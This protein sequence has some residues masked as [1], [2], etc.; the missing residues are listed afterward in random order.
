MNLIIENSKSN[1]KDIVLKII[2]DRKKEIF[3]FFNSNV[4]DLPFN[5]Y[6]YDSIE[7]LVD[8]LRKRGFD[9]DP[10]YMCAC[11]KDEDN[12]LNFFEPKD[13]P[14]NNEW[15]KEEYEDVILHELIHAIQFNLFGSAPEWLCEGIAKY[16]DGTYSYGIKWL[17]EDYINDEPIP[18]QS[19]IENEFG[20]H[21]Y[22]SYDYAYLM[23]SYLIESMGKDEFV[24]LIK[25][26]K[27]NSVKD[28]L[29]DK[30]INY[31]NSKYFSNYLDKYLN[32]DID[33]P[34]YLFHGSCKRL[35][36]LIP[37]LSHDSNGNSN[38]IADAIFLFPSF[39]KSTP[40]AFKDTIKECSEGLDWNFEIPSDNDFPLMKMSNVN[41]DED[42]VGYI[43]VFENSN[44]M[45]KDDD[46][47]QY[48][49]YKE[50]V[51]IDVVEVCFKDYMKYYDNQDEHKKR[52]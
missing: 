3:N 46:S 2:N 7:S 40:Y 43:Y 4:I 10:D 17:L 42:I 50:L 8:G 28:G 6:I 33:N 5:V 32:Q 38:N 13:N 30:A 37:R 48:K 52:R 27:I 31:Y 26:N 45:I 9:K 34:K 16:L 20:N 25:N 36:K 14:G 44:D 29:L 24:D 18:N 22:D 41:V 39:L 35:F 12:S 19:E 21:D 1:Y 23:V 51:P 47:Y 15:S 49:C 11:F